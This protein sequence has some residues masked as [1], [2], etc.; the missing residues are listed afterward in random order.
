[1]A[2][3][4]ATITLASSDIMDNSLS[5]SNTATLTKAGSSTGLPDT[6]GLRRK[7]ISTTPAVDLIKREPEGLTA[8]G[9]N[10]LYIKNTG[11]ST[12]KY[13]TISIGDIGG[14]STKLGRLYGGDWMF[15]PWAAAQGVKEFF[16]L[17]L[18]GTWAA[19]DTMAFD[20]VTVT[21]GSATKS[22]CA[23]NIAAGVYPNWTAADSGDTVVFTAREAYDTPGAPVVGWFTVT[24]ASGSDATFGVGTITT[25][26]D[27]NADIICQLNHATETVIEYMAIYE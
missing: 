19:G 16:T 10:K 5:I 25:G 14:T 7:R 18:T 13:A 2:T 9:A 22:V 15:I 6:S 8:N 17:T 4:T 21:A 27:A 11:T 26:T 23:T 12:T 3:T 20:G 24:D 1:M